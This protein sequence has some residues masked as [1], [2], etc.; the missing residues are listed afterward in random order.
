MSPTVAARPLASATIFLSYN[1]RYVLNGAHMN[2]CIVKCREINLRTRKAHDLF[3]GAL[4][5][6]QEKQINMTISAQDL[7]LSDKQAAAYQ[8]EAGKKSGGCFIATACCGSP[9]DPLVRD[10]R[11][12]RDEILMARAPGRMLAAAYARFSPPIADWIRGR[13]WARSIVRHT[14][15]RPLAWVARR[16]SPS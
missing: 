10:L 3:L 8:A 4:S 6:E 11:R 9:T 2:G 7:A 14:I 15:V 13:T 1:S 16:I 5:A 12:F